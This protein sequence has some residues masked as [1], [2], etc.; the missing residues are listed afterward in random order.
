MRI[1]IS[2]HFTVGKLLRFV[3]P[4]II[5][6]IFTSIYGVV[7]GFFVSNYV[8][9]TPFAAV[10]LIMPLLMAVGA[11][12]FMLGSGGSALV[13]KTCGE[14]DA[15]RANR[16]FSMVIY[17][18]VIIGFAAALV[19]FF[20]IRPIASLMGARGEMLEYCVL[21]AR[22]LIFT[23]PMFMLQNMFQSFFITA[24]KPHL[25]LYVILAAG[26]A[27]MVLDFLFIVPLGTRR[28]SCGDRNRRDYR[29][30][31]AADLLCTSQ[32]QPVETGANK[33][34]MASAVAQ[35][36]QRCVGNDDEPVHVYCEYTVQSPA[37]AFCR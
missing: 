21:Y 11:I 1:Q 24:E 33:A 19:C 22:I 26:V 36:L 31:R 12:G 27:N 13:A 29:R 23:L 10:N 6:M 35:L 18:A 2:D 9:K 5:M 8:G 17:A 20:L 7:D 4:S 14:G 28:R 16:Y 37:D 25:G 30:C 34:G 15:K 32:H 3:F